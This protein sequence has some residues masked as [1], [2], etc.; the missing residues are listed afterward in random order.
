MYVYQ[1]NPKTAHAE[2]NSHVNQMCIGNGILGLPSMS[3]WEV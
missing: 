3:Q 2:K 1:S